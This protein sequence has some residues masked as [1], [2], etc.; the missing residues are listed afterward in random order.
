MAQDK[1][2]INIKDGSDWK[3]LSFHKFVAASKPLAWSDRER[4][5]QGRPVPSG[6]SRGSDDRPGPPTSNYRVP[7]ACMHIV[8]TSRPTNLDFIF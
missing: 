2:M 7:P 8:F 6:G 5:D 3:S 1:P 4:S